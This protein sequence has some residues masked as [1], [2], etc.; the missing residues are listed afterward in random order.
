M[1]DKITAETITQ[2][3]ANEIAR[4]ALNGD[5]RY[6]HEAVGNEDGDINT[7]ETEVGGRRIIR[8]SS[9]SEVAVYDRNGAL[10]IVADANGPV[11]ITIL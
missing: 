6:S 4:A 9:T 2:T 7:M 5:A 1:S 11:A 10:V 3:I 8:A